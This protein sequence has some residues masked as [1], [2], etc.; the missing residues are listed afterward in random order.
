M[1]PIH[2]D[3]HSFRTAEAFASIILA[4]TTGTIAL[5]GATAMAGYIG[6]GGIETSL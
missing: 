1:G 4:L 5:I 3:R 6:G 2:S